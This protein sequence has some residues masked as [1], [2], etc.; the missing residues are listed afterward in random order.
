MK[1]EQARSQCLSLPRDP[2]Y[3]RGEVAKAWQQKKAFLMDHQKTL[4]QLRADRQSDYA[5]NVG[6]AGSARELATYFAMVTKTTSDLIEDLGGFGSEKAVGRATEIYAAIKDGKTAYTLVAGDALTAVT[7][8]LIDAAADEIPTIRGAK[9]VKDFAENMVHMTELP[10]GMAA[11]RR[12]FLNQMDAL[13]TEIS[14]S[15]TKIDQLQRDNE[16]SEIE[17][18]FQTFQAVRQLCEGPQSPSLSAP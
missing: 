4:Q 15:Q 17:A 8:V 1:S 10:E 9:A 3:Y 14:K 13:N 18:L 16:S 7:D 11:A 6:D 5:W 2:T 12:E